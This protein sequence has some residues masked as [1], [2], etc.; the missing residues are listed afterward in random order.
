MTKFFHVVNLSCMTCPPEENAA[1]DPACK[2]TSL[3]QADLDADDSA[4]GLEGA[5]DYQTAVTTPLHKLCVNLRRKASD[6]MLKLHTQACH[7]L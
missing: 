6:F 4:C 2:T 7:T 3:N 5:P 1:P